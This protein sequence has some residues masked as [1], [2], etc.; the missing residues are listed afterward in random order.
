[1]IK[2]PFVLSEYPKEF[3]VMW[4]KISGKSSL[5]IGS[6]PEMVHF[7]QP[8][9]LASATILRI[10]SNVNSFFCSGETAGS[11]SQQWRQLL[12]HR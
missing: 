3:L 10:S 5:S 1:V 2:V 12:L 6:P 9:D 4:S 8:I 7:W 11:Q